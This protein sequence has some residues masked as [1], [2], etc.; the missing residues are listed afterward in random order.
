MGDFILVKPGKYKPRA[1]W[2]LTMD[3]R[4]RALAER[5][6]AKG[7]ELAQGTKDHG[8]LVLGMVVMVQNQ[9]GKSALN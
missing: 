6:R 2:L 5:H 9:V 8:P 3:Q 4:E 7:L 1:E